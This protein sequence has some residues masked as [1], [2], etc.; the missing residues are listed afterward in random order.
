MYMAGQEMK[1]VL[2]RDNITIQKNLEKVSSTSKSVVYH[3][4]ETLCVY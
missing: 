1:K 4:I 3:D 2:E